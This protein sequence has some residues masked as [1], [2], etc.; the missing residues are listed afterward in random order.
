MKIL[1]WNIN[2]IRSVKKDKSLKNMFDSLDA[3]I[4]CLQ[5]TKIT[6]INVVYVNFSH[7]I[8]QECPIVL[9]KNGDHCAKSLS[10]LL[11]VVRRCRQL[12]LP[13]GGYLWKT[14]L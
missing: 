10:P 1:T 8:L 2:G 13:F 4:I 11:R 5:E 6:S 7:R 3:D 9:R 14:G 12:P